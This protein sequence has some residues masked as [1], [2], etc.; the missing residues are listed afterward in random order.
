MTPGF[1]R[2]LA[3]RVREV[4]SRASLV[5]KMALESGLVWNLSSPGLLEGARALTGAAQNPALG[6]MRLDVRA[7][8][9]MEHAFTVRLDREA[10][11]FVPATT[12]AA[13]TFNPVLAGLIVV[14]GNQGRPPSIR[15]SM[16]SAL[17]RSTKWRTWPQRLSR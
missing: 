2:G 9:T 12:S 10:R 13:R 4:P 7:A 3:E 11:S 16:A 17:S 14:P 1:L 15:R 6:A 8:K 5:A